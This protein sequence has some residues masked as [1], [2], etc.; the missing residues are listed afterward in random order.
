MDIPASNSPPDPVLVAFNRFG[1]GARPG[2]RDRVAHD[3]RGYLKAELRQPDIALIPL[4]DPAYASLPGSTPAIQASMA[5]NFQRKLDREH[6]AAAT[7]Q[8]AMAS[9]QATPE[10]AAPAQ[11]VPPPAPPAKP[12][13]PIEA[14]LFRAEA[15][16][17][18]DKAFGAEAGFVERLVYFWSNHFCVSVAKDNIVRASAGAF[19]R[20]A[21][22]PFVLGRFADM[23]MAVERHPAMLFYLDNQQSI[24]PDSRAGK[25]RRRG[26]NENLAR[27]IMELHT[28]GVGSGYTQADVTSFARILTGWTM[29][30][31]KGRLG[32]PGSSVFNANAHEPG[33]AV[34]LGKTYP[35][36]GMGQ[37]EAAL[38]DI[39]RHPATAHHIATELARHFIADDPPPAAVARL[40][41][42][43]AKSDGNLRALAAT[44]IDMPEA[45]SAPL[46]KMR[47]PFDYIA[48]IRRAA[49]PGPANDPG[50]SLNWL[51]AL[52]EP[53]WQPPGP[54]G[55]SDQADSWTSAEGMKIRLDIAWQAARQ[56]KDIGN[57]ND[58]LDAV[59][60]PSASPETRQA[61]ARAESKQQGLALLLMAPEFQ[62]R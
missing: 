33:D 31:R 54:N 28:L 55:F 45:W 12:A 59:I 52:G 34:L 14:T 56:V 38:N 24:G 32:E 3:P 17:R 29:A 7:A 19:E 42:V 5:A 23:L 22:R 40:A 44:L 20:E 47:S 43:F 2:D 50:Q 8:P 49:G 16:A 13:P 4:D 21:I 1:L 53:L 41:K 18:L 30:G 15:Q 25:N 61:V 35:A 10:P 9:T 6:M 51:N 57:P 60:G 62:R 39:A 37:A 46:A 26:L 48:A 27:E 58:M 11:P 36:G